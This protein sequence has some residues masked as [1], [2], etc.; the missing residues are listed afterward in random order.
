MNDN[1]FD[2]I[3]GMLPGAMNNAFG[4]EPGA[5]M[6]L[7]SAAPGGLGGLGGFM[8]KGGY[9]ML[10]GIGQSLMSS[11]RN[12]PLAGFGKAMQGIDSSNAAGSQRQMLV[13]MLKRAGFSDE[14]AMKYAASPELAQMAMRM[15]GSGTGG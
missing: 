7:P 1:I 8:Q 11:P 13:A 2:M 9:D 14:D 12:N 3:G 15:T 6:Q 4:E 5:P 10:Q